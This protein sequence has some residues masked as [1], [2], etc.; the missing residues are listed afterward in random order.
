MDRQLLFHALGLHG[1]THGRFYK[2]VKAIMSNVKRQ[3]RIDESLSES[4]ALDLG[5]PQG[6]VLSPLLFNLTIHPIVSCLA[7]GPFNAS[8][9]FGDKDL[10]A[11]AFADD[12]MS[13]LDDPNMIQSELDRVGASA[14]ANRV[15]FSAKKTQVVLVTADT[16]AKLAFSHLSWSLQGKQIEAANE[17]RYHGIYIGAVRESK[18]PGDHPAFASSPV[19]D[20]SSSISE[21]ASSF[22]RRLSSLFRAHC[23]PSGLSTSK[24]S[25]LFLQELRPILDYGCATMDL[26]PQEIVKM[27]NL[28]NQALRLFLFGSTDKGRYSEWFLCNEF[29][30]IPWHHRR[31]ELQMRYFGRLIDSRDSPQGSLRTK[32]VVYTMFRK[33]QRWTTRLQ[34]Y[35]F[36]NRRCPAAPLS[37]PDWRVWTGSIFRHWSDIHRTYGLAPSWHLD[38]ADGGIPRAISGKSATVSWNLAK[39]FRPPRFGH[40]RDH[41]EP[42]TLDIRTRVIRGAVLAFAQT[43]WEPTRSTL[44]RQRDLGANCLGNGFTPRTIPRRCGHKVGRLVMTAIRSGAAPLQ[45]EFRRIDKVSS[46]TCP[47]CGS[48]DESALHFTLHCPAYRGPRSLLFEAAERHLPPALIATLHNSFTPSATK[49]ALLTD[50][51]PSKWSSFYP[52]PNWACFDALPPLAKALAKVRLPSRLDWHQACTTFFARAWKIRCSVTKPDI[53]PSGTR[54]PNDVRL[55]AALRGRPSYPQKVPR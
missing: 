26:S 28:Q 23:S 11:S 39:N 34:N 9:I 48:A 41:I 2:M 14:N 49:F 24:T 51:G 46:P 7:D 37:R 50:P 31:A 3:V 25:E 17:Y 33:F 16:A 52:I 22:R 32:T 47:L 5:V 1:N 8:T 13:I 12:L 20:W 18:F 38:D 19:L 44:S 40:A 42:S 45:V 29:G 55:I 36:K 4:F 54:P 15:L 21:K 6:S 53:G 43:F 30:V 27:R 35:S 10:S